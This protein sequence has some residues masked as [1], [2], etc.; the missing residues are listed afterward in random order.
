M[1]EENFAKELS[2]DYVDLAK[3]YQDKGMSAEEFIYN[4]MSCLVWTSF[5]CFGISDAKEFLFNLV[6]HQIDGAIMYKNLSPE[7]RQKLIA[8]ILSKNDV[9]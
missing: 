4:I 3:K 2:L 5:K 8:G 6:K 7:E 1:N 9:T